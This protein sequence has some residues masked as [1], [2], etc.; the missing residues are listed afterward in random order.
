M[1]ELVEG[2]SPTVTEK[3]LQQAI[4]QCARMLGW[5]CYHT[6]D[7]RGSEPGFPDLVLLRPNSM[8]GNPLLFAE[9]KT[10]RGKLSSAQEGW[11]DALERAG[12]WTFVWRPADWLNGSVEAILRGD[13][14]SFW[15]GASAPVAQE[16]RT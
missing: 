6:F 1:A 14:H 8:T 3:Q 4:V 5:R 9:L 2:V 10:A 7:S 15:G 16:S 11:L 13:G 12:Q